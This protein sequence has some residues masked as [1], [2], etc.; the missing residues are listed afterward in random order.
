MSSMIGRVKG[1][2]LSVTSLI[3]AVLGGAAMLLSIRPSVVH[4]QDGGSNCTNVC[5]TSCWNAPFLCRDNSCACKCG[6]STCDC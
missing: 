6:L 3:A 4:A 5:D 2:A 1:I